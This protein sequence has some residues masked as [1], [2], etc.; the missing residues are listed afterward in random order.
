M[1]ANPFLTLISGASSSHA[2]FRYFAY[3]EL[4]Q[5]AT[6]GS[7]AAGTRRTAM[8]GDQK[9]N[10]TMWSALAREALL[11]LGKD[12]QLLLR[13]GKPEGKPGASVMTHYEK[14]SS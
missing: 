5:L 6:E 11:L 12:Y 10:P 7:P 9:Y 2:Y 3:A 8:F 1:T 4:K 14:G 13:R